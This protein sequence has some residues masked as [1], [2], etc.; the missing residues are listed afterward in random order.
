MYTVDG[1]KCHF[2]F[3]YQF[4]TYYGCVTVNDDAAWCALVE[5]LLWSSSDW[6][7]CNLSPD[8]TAVTVSTMKSH[9]ETSAGSAHISKGPAEIMTPTRGSTI[10][11][12][13]D[14]TTA[15]RG[16]EIRQP[17]T[18]TGFMSTT[19]SKADTTTFPMGN[20][21][22]QAGTITGFMGTTK[23][24]ADTTSVASSSNTKQAE[25]TTG[26]MGSSMSEADTTSVITS[27]TTDQT[28]TIT[29]S[30][31]INMSQA[32]TA[33]ATKDTTTGQADT[34]T[35]TSYSTRWQVN[36]TTGIIISL[37]QWQWSNQ[38]DPFYQHGLAVTPT[39]IRNYIIKCGMKLPT[40]SQTATV[41]TLK[42]GN[43]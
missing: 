18:T 2:P 19:R 23:S 36:T 3:N 37:P 5:T 15:T 6:E 33:T 26:S 34:A 31:S 40:L 1:Q 29:G 24:Q 25:T 9:G 43:R 42:F 30:M 13:A 32:D 21:M 7:Y 28:E 16:S 39:W 35:D 8:P 17:E 38:R 41:A 10:V 22:T 27:T 11:S 20:P 4:V 14:T 12:E